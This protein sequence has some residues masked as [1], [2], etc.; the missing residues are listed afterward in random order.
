MAD[1]V[2][3]CERHGAR[4]KLTCAEC[5]AP[6]C[7]R[8]MVRTDVGL[9]CEACATPSVASQAPTS[10]RRLLLAIGAAV[11]GLGIL[12]GALILGGILPGSPAET[13]PAA[14]P[15]G[16]W[17][18][19]PALTAVRG[20]TSAVS[21]PD[22][23]VAVVG[24]GLGSVPV[25]ATEIFDPGSDAWT[26]SGDLGQARR[27][28][29]T[30]LLDDGRLLAAGGISAEGLLASTELWDPATGSWEP[31]AGMRHPRLGHTATVLN[32]G[33]VL[34]TGGTGDSGAASGGG[35]TVR[36]TATAE[37]Y[38]PASE[39]WTPI[40]DMLVPRFEHTATLLPDGR[41]LIAGGLGVEG[42][43]VGPVAS[44]ELYDPNT[45][46]FSRTGRMAQPRTDH[47][48]VPLDDGRVLVAA[49]D[50]GT[51]AIASA[52]VF[53]PARGAFSETATL[54]QAR[55]GHTATVLGDGTVLVVGGEFFNQ[56]TR[57]SLASA[58]RY[59]PGEQAWVSAGEMNC[60]R[61]EHGAA[62]L[63]DGSVLAAAGD[64]T[65]PGEAPIAQSCIDAY[66]P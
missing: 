9:R 47:A 62:L 61:S 24:G 46:T 2:L 36:P 66:R 21:L 32:D 60:P 13:E 63:P 25:P 3:E 38:D 41:V 43:E 65:F 30:V 44:A 8:C 19:L 23:R 27:G 10:R 6:I 18:K 59:D 35:Q 48:A 22:G 16:D 1:Q 11:L 5:D 31:T 58:E 37:V 15:V 52:E 45:R 28:H 42:D 14:A 26:R 56:G 64:A 51:S 49:G 53:E 54:R 7:P 12:T 55:R 40:G 39:T 57:T 17:S 29:R 20:S 50:A 34:V 4:T 33:M